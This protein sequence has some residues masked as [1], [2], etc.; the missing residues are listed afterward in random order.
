MPAVQIRDLPQSTYELLKAEARA[1]G[2]S[3]TK[4][5]E[6]ILVDF[7]AARATAQRDQRPSAI[8]A[9]FSSETPDQIEARA[10]KRALL[11]ARIDAAEPFIP[12]APFDAASVVREMRDER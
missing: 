9:P 7:F 12:D 11:F 8:A 6:A 3:I 4:Q 5:T 2:R 10:Q 1:N